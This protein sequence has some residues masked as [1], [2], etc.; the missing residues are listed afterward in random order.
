MTGIGHI[1]IAKIGNCRASM[2]TVGRGPFGGN[3]PDKLVVVKYTNSGR[4][5]GG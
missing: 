2:D 1:Q 3:K 5:G 4:G